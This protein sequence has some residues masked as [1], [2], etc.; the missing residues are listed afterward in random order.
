MQSNTK[1]GDVLNKF[2]WKHSRQCFVCS[3]ENTTNGNKI[4]IE[5]IHFIICVHGGDHGSGKF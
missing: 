2:W 5:D 3:V 1:A 4:T